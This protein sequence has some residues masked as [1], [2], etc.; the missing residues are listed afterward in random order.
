[1]T[2]PMTDI[3]DSDPCPTCD[4]LRMFA[5]DECDMRGEHTTRMVECEDCSSDGDPRD[6]D[7]GDESAAEVEWEAPS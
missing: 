3:D 5:I 1:M 6:E 2:S 4:G 7:D